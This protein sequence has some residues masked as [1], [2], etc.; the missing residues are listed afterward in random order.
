MILTVWGSG[1]KFRGIA[2]AEQLL[3]KCVAG[4]GISVAVRRDR[5]VIAAP[6]PCGARVRRARPFESR[7]QTIHDP[8]A[9]QTICDLPIPPPAQRPSGHT[10]GGFSN[11]SVFRP[12]GKRLDGRARNIPSLHSDTG[13]PAVAKRVGAVRRRSDR[14]DPPGLQAAV[15]D[16]VPRRSDDRSDRLPIRERHDRQADRVSH[17]GAAANQDRELRRVEASGAEASWKRSFASST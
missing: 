11:R 9:P 8:A 15:G 12:P 13:Q 1:Y 14:V 2:V 17:G 4:A 3:L 6:R 10:A 5:A 16:R 7:A